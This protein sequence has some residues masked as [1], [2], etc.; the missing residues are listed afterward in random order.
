MS[1]RSGKG[2]SNLEAKAAFSSFVSKDTPRIAIPPA[3]RAFR[4]E[5][6]GDG[7]ELRLWTQGTEDRR[8]LWRAIGETELGVVDVEV[9]HPDL[10]DVFLQLTREER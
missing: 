8:R 6:D 5:L 4:A 7:R 3:L 1:H 2:K 10:E 9:L